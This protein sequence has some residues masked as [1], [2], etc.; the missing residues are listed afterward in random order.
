[1]RVSGDLCLRRAIAEGCRGPTDRAINAG[2][3]N[4]SSYLRG[5]TDTTLIGGDPQ[6]GCGDPGMPFYRTRARP[7]ELPI[8][9]GA[10][11]TDSWV[12]DRQG[13]GARAGS[14]SL[15]WA[16]QSQRHGAFAQESRARV[17]LRRRYPRRCRRVRR[18]SG[19]LGADG[20]GLQLLLGPGTSGF[21]VTFLFLVHDAEVSW[22]RSTRGAPSAR[23]SHPCARP[24]HPAHPTRAAALF[25]KSVPKSVLAHLRVMFTRRFH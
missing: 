3:C 12:T 14:K 24:S 21:D 25:I 11:P 22:P 13:L 23:P 7:P 20:A 9:D 17:S 19:L 18:S 4:L 8:L 6:F 5:P 1:M 15:A 10:A 16:P 2:T